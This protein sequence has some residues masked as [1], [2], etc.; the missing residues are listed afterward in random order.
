MVT[1]DA[2]LR[3]KGILRVAELPMRLIFRGIGDRARAGLEEA[4]G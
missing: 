4:L 2:D 3:L 1:Y